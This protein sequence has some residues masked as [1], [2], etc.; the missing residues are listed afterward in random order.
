MAEDGEEADTVV[1]TVTVIVMMIC[2]KGTVS[3]KTTTGVHIVR[4][5]NQ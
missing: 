4:A 5:M 1:V 2:Q 3:V